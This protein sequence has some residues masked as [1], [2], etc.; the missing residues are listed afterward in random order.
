MPFAEDQNMIQAIAPERPNQALNIWVLPIRLH[1]RA[2]SLD[3]A[4]NVSVDEAAVVNRHRRFEM[5]PD[6]PYDQRL[7]F[8]C[9][10]P[11]Y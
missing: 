6:R 9:R 7:D 4:R 5:F 11:A 8:D 1:A 10:Y 3:D 2:A